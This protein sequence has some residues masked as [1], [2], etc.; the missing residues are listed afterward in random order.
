MSNTDRQRGTLF[1]L[2]I[3]D[4]LGAAIDFQPP[5]T[6]ESVTGCRGGGPHGLAPGEWI[7]DRSMSLALAVK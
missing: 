4:A 1:G 5:G 3:S 7:D 2:A 6:F